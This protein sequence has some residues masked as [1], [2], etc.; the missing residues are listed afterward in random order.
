[1]TTIL[2]QILTEW[3]RF[4]ASDT[5]LSGVVIAVV[6]SLV[7]GFIAAAMPGPRGPLHVCSC[8]WMYRQ[9]GSESDRAFA[10]RQSRHIE[11]CAALVRQPLH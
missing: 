6:V 9:G 3:G 11:T 5:I 2:D 10:R 7:A 4:F 8:G 1:M